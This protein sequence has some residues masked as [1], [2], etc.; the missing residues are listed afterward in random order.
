MDRRRR[1]LMFHFRLRVTQLMKLLRFLGFALVFHVPVTLLAQDAAQ[2]AVD[3][4]PNNNPEATPS[5]PPSAPALPELSVL[6]E[7]FKQ[8][9]LG[10]AADDMRI[11]VEMRRLENEVVNDPEI[12]AA[13]IAANAAGTDLE[14]RERLRSYYDLYYRRIAEKTSRPELRSAAE[15]AKAEHIALL[16]QPRVRPGSGETPPPKK[17]KQKKK[18]KGFFES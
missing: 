7:A 4:P 15:S 3:L 13:K 2:P 18:H 8:T 17:K 9:T 16:S 10:K 12:R 14:K 11:R 6:D 1:A 5:P